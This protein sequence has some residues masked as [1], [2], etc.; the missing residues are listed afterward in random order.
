MPYA[1]ADTSFFTRR[2]LVFILIVLL[3]VGLGWA[4]NS[5]LSHRVVQVFTGPIET[6]MIEEA[7]KVEEPP[8]PPPPKLTEAPPP[9]VP[10]PELAIDIPM[11]TPP[12]TAITQT[13]Q[14]VPPPQPPPQPVQQAGPPPTP[15][16]I[17][18]RRP[19]TKPEYPAASRRAGEE[20]TVVLEL[21][22]LP[23]GRVGEARVR[24]SSGYPRLDEAAIREAKRSWRFIPG[25]ENGKP[26]AMWHATKVTFS[27]T[28]G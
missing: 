24:Q 12:A 1:P 3:H 20:G 16:R 11:D 14:Q 17:D 2:S 6:R 21:Y 22:I 10:P 26:V 23:N 13:T 5:G 4:L 19:P 25:T 18:P 28:D 9:F 27:L 15:P 7:P 8:P